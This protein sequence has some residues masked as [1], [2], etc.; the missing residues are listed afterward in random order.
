[1][2]PLNTLWTAAASVAAL[3]VHLTTKSL[4]G[5][6]TGSYAEWGGIFCAI[7]KERNKGKVRCELLYGQ[8]VRG[9]GSGHGDAC[10]GL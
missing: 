10:Q 4:P 5:A 7:R 3:F 9:Y 1:M 2:N 8:E 6:Y